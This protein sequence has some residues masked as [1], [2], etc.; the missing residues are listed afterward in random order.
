MRNI[1]YFIFKK[2]DIK[3]TGMYILYRTN[4]QNI[5]KK[6]EECRKTFVR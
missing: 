3:I 4:E 1:K 6:N 2:K 5:K